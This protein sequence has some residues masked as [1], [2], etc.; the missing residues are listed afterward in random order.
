MKFSKRMMKATAI[1][2]AT[3]TVLSTPVIESVSAKS[4]DSDSK[5]KAKILLCSYGIL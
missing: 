2:L 4:K 1:S 3:L 5:G